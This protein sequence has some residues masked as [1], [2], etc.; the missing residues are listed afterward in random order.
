MS[1]AKF[2]KGEWIAYFHANDDFGG[3]YDQVVIG[4][5]SYNDDPRNHYCAHKVIIDG[6]EDTDEEGIANAHLIAAAPDMYDLL[7][8]IENDNGQVPEWLWDK[9]QLTLAKA[10]GEKQK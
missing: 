6:V 3:G 2:T 5:D 9:I 8:T 10:R 7:S 1:K 4:M